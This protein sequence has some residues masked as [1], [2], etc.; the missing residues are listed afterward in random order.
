MSGPSSGVTAIDASGYG[1]RLKQLREGRQMTQVALAKRAR[2]TQAYI[3]DLEAGTK[4]N[5]SLAVFAR[6]AAG[7]GVPLGTL[8]GLTP[9]PRRPAPAPRPQ[10]LRDHSPAAQQGALAKALARAQELP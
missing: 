7:L 9:D 8:L 3:S 2:V 6:L 1:T 4:A 5:P 10:P